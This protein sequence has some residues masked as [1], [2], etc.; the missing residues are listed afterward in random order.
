MKVLI[1]LFIPLL[2]FSSCSDKH[3]ESTNLYSL[4]IQ[5]TTSKSVK[6]ITYRYGAFLYRSHFKTIDINVN[7]NYI[8]DFE[9]NVCNRSLLSDGLF[10]ETD[11]IVIVYEKERFKSFTCGDSFSDQNCK[12][13]RNPLE[14]KYRTTI[15]YTITEE[16]YQNAE[17]CDERCE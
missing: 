6:I 11:S 5:N 3:C 8:E 1:L 14:F 17:E 2:L 12:E 13:A 16:D 4:R 15:E 10:N 7:S 9:F